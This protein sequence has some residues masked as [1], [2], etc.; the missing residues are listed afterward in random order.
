MKKLDYETVN[1]HCLFDTDQCVILYNDIRGN[2]SASSLV[3]TVFFSAMSFGKIPSHSLGSKQVSQQGPAWIKKKTDTIWG[4]I[5]RQKVS[6][7]CF[8]DTVLC[9]LCHFTQMDSADQRYGWYSLHI[10]HWNAVTVLNSSSVRKQ[11]VW[12]YIRWKEKQ[13]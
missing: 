11:V 5:I 8:R 9:C 6:E 13:N 2:E 7:H 10:G 1:L 4:L 3:G 12:K